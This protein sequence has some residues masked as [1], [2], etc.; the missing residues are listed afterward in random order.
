MEDSIPA[1][2]NR[3]A[4]AL[5]CW[6]R[7]WIVASAASSTG[8]E[9]V[10]F[11]RICVAAAIIPLVRLLTKSGAESI[12]FCSGKAS[13]RGITLWVSDLLEPIPKPPISMAMSVSMWML[14]SEPR[15]WSCLG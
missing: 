12:L 13:V 7:S 5:L 1:G 11:S 2:I 10:N 3:V 9:R 6:K 14:W 4:T 15:V 8:G